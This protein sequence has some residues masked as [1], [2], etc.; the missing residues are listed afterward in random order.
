MHGERLPARLDHDLACDGAA[1]GHRA[2]RHGNGF[3]LRLDFSVGR[4]I[5]PGPLVVRPPVSRAFSEPPGAGQSA[6]PSVRIEHDAVRGVRPPAGR[7]AHVF[8]W[9]VAQVAW[10]AL[11]VLPRRVPV[12]ELVS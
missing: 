2:D 12:I 6:R 4:A 5:G 7:Y 11:L 1:Q 9:V 8:E 10:R 3:V